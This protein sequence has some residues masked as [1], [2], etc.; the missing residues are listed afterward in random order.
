VFAALA[1][2][3]ADSGNIQLAMKVLY[4]AEKDAEE[5]PSLKL[6]SV[7]RELLLLSCNEDAAPGLVRRFFIS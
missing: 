6:T 1:R 3:A 5:N 4:W 7:W 2:A